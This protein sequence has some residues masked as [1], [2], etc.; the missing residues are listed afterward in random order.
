M[1]KSEITHGSEM[2]LLSKSFPC[3]CLKSGFG[4]QSRS[5]LRS[6]P[7]IGFGTSLRDATQ[8]ARLQPP[9]T[10]LVFRLFIYTAIRVSCTCEM[11]EWE[12]LPWCGV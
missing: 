4:T 1:G 8:K 9:Q 10:V 11:L 12:L 7:A 6:A 3:N 2:I 5:T